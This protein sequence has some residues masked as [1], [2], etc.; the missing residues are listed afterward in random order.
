MDV[1]KIDQSLSA[2]LG[3]APP[4]D[5]LNAEVSFDAGSEFNLSFFDG[6]EDSAQGFSDP[7]SVGSTSVSSPTPE[8]PSSQ[9]VAVSSVSPPLRQTQPEIISY[10][11]ALENH[12][13]QLKLH[14]FRFEGDFATPSARPLENHLDAFQEWHRC[15]PISRPLPVKELLDLPISSFHSNFRVLSRFRALIAKNVL[16]ILNAGNIADKNLFSRRSVE[17]ES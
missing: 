5:K 1:F 15:I 10:R 13:V 9:L 14:T 3:S 2:N 7:G 11:G 16:G 17:V 4:P 6:P 8:T 12:G